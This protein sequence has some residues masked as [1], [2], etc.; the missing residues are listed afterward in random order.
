MSN[1]NRK[2]LDLEIQAQSHL[3]VILD[4]KILATSIKPKNRQMF[5]K[6]LSVKMLV[7]NPTN[8]NNK[9]K[10]SCQQ[11][12]VISNS[13]KA[14]K[15]KNCRKVEKLTKVLQNNCRK[16]TNKFMIMSQYHKP[17]KASLYHQLQFKFNQ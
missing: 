17:Q 14:F 9:F 7:K 2:E 8:L 15:R 10:R 12:N 16:P 6:L 5:Q 3:K 11:I 1:T 13:M 4:L